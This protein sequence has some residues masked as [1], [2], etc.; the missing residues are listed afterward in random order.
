MAAHESSDRR[1]QRRPAANEPLIHPAADAHSGSEG[2]GAALLKAA[3]GGDELVLH[4]QRVV[5]LGNP[6]APRGYQ[7]LTRVRLQDGRL[8]SLPEFVSVAQGHVPLPTL[9]RRVLRHI[10]QMM[11]GRDRTLCRSGLTLSIGVTRES[12][13]DADFVQFLGGELRRSGIAE[14]VLIEVT[15]AAAVD[16]L[17]SD[18]HLLRSLCTSGCRLSIDGVGPE[19]KTLATLRHLPIGLVN[20]DSQLVRRVL[21]DPQAEAAV[22]SIAVFARTL[23]ITPAAKCVDTTKLSEHLGELGVELGQGYAFGWP[24]PFAQILGNP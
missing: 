14:R 7:L 10:T 24:E 2:R 22:R 11:H 16:G 19:Q 12:V 20:I 8:L 15:P 3:L 17:N 4:A 23:G 6:T 13:A 5:S 21:S 9:D 1:W 18:D